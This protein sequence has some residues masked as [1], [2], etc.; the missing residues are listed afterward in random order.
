MQRN[1]MIAAMSLC[2]WC[3]ILTSAN[4]PALAQEPIAYIGHGAMFDRN[5]NQIAATPRLIESAQQFYL[6]TLSALTNQEQFTRFKTERARLFEGWEWDHQSKL[7]ANSALID[8]LLHEVDSSQLDDVQGKNNLIKQQLQLRLFQPGK[9]RRFTL[10]VPLTDLLSASGSVGIEPLSSTTAQRQAYIDECAAVG[11]PIPPTWGTTQWIN[12]GTLTTKF[13]GA[14]L[15]YVE[16]FN[17]I[18]SK[19]RGACIA[20][21]RAANNTADWD[22]LGIICLGQ[23]TSKACFWD[24]QVNGQ[25]TAIPQGTVKPLIEFEGGSGLEGGS[26]GRCTGCHTGENPYVIHPSSVLGVVSVM[27]ND[28]YEPLV[29]PSWP[30]NRGPS[31]VLDNI[32]PAPAGCLG[33]HTQTG[34]GRFPKISSQFNNGGA[35]CGAVLQPAV[36]DPGGTMPPGN[37]GGYPTHT[38]TLL[39]QCSI[40]M[41]VPSF[42]MN[43]LTPSHWSNAYSFCPGT[44]IVADGSA[45]TGENSYSWGWCQT[46]G[47][48]LPCLLGSGQE[49]GS[50]GQASTHSFGTY[51]A[52]GNYH[53]F[54]RAMN[55][56][57][58][59]FKSV[60]VSIGTETIRMTSGVDYFPDPTLL[61][62]GTAQPNVTYAAGPSFLPLS[63]TAWTPTDPI[64]AAARNGTSPSV[65]QPYPGWLDSWPDPPYWISAHIDSNQY[66]TPPASAL[67]AIP[68]DVTTADVQSAYL[69]LCWSADDKLGDGPSGPNPIGVFV[70]GYPV[71]ATFSGGPF[72]TYTCSLS[73]NLNAGTTVVHTGL[74]NYLYLYVRDSFG[75]ASGIR[76][77]AK[78][79]ASAC[80]SLDLISITADGGS[81]SSGQC[82][83][84][85]CTK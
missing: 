31:N 72:G 65:V 55:G 80:P 47:P 43:G 60:E 69:R 27:G 81:G 9:G 61:V 32:P 3:V 49:T 66:G 5:G 39:D 37:P 63:A 6:G 62:V 23:D 40:S 77:D 59:E 28:W 10:P 67:F 11:V 76:Y 21:P 85:K 73:G 7:I 19:P 84:R 75:V 57:F 68:F 35:Y 83:G 56:S 29:H 14:D 52:S 53:F 48:N 46:Q 74:D 30:Q 45:T 8:W 50:A 70:N 79:Y 1:S 18:S 36:A 58:D 12:N 25:N 15:P 78:I 38:T 71:S 13:I 41:P 22:L 44:Q 51:G 34:S 26:G 4:Q 17:Y 2:A 16:V 64:F 33:C 20:L 82:V 42:N 54:L 24:N